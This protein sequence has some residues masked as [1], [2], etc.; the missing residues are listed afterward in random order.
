MV[1]DA[2]VA[3]RLLFRS[4]R[5]VPLYEGASSVTMRRWVQAGL[6][7][8]SGRCHCRFLLPKQFARVV[9]TTRS[10]LY[11]PVSSVETFVEL[12]LLLAKCGTWLHVAGLH[13]TGMRAANSY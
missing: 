1:G 12:Q 8:S 10:L 13:P 6:F 5:R 4:G 2:D 3:R 9:T 11:L 7:E